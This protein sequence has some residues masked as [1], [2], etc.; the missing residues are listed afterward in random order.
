MKKP[1]KWAT[2]CTKAIILAGGYGTRLYPLT[3][4]ISKQ[5]LPVYNKP[6]IF[7]PIQTFSI[8]SKVNW[9]DIPILI[10]GTNEKSL[11]LIREIASLFSKKIFKIKT[12]HFQS[13]QI[14]LSII[15]IIHN[16]IMTFTNIYCIL[17][18]IKMELK[19]T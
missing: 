3:Y 19:Q 13:I 9:K 12:V 2:T 1:L 16:I 14:L 15:T 6:M 18:I 4:A 5:M 11:L 10:E 17:T 7:Y 8:S